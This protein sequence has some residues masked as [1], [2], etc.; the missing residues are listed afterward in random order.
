[1]LPARLQ[2]L[3]LK[4]VAWLFCEG[5]PEHDWEGSK[6]RTSKA[7][8][9]PS[10]HC[11]SEGIW[12]H[13]K[14]FFWRPRIA[15]HNTIALA[16]GAASAIGEAVSR[17]FV[18]VGAASNREELFALPLCCTSFISEVHSRCESGAKAMRKRCEWKQVKGLSKERFKGAFSSWKD[19]KMTSAHWRRQTWNP[20]PART[21]KNWFSPQLKFDWNWLFQGWLFEPLALNVPII[22]NL[23]AVQRGDWEATSQELWW[24]MLKQKILFAPSSD[25]RS[26]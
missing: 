13:L 15:R 14:V 8:T 17:S 6:P 2:L 1:M 7:S 23:N 11:K 24:A 20:K 3:K 22:S 12:T 21:D 4:I 9:K 18:G 26:P 16:H 5:A 19:R 10:W 25:A